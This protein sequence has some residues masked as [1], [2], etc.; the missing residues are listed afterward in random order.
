MTNTLSHVLTLSLMP[1][2][3]VVSIFNAEVAK[4]TLFD[5]TTFFARID[6][7]ECAQKVSKDCAP[8]E[9]NVHNDSKECAQ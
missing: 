3:T 2:T 1:R 8:I 7:T 5:C 4:R 6:L 9:K